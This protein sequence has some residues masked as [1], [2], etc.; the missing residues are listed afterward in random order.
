MINGLY[1]CNI[2]VV[3]GDR[4][5]VVYLEDML[6]L[7]YLGKTALRE[8]LSSVEQIQQELKESLVAEGYETRQQII[9]L[10][11]EIKREMLDDKRSD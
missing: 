3:S 2:K 11:Q 6:K 9:D 7:G 4:E 5:L 8:P 1:L 10:I